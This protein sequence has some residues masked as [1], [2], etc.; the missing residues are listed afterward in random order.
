MTETLLNRLSGLA[1]FAFGVAL[2]LWLIPANTETVDYG[3]IRPDTVPKAC[4]WAFVALGLVQAALPRGRVEVDVREA[5]WVA[6]IAALSALAVWGM[7]RF[8]FLATGPVFAAV[9]VVLIREKRWYWAAA[10]IFGAP[11][12]TWLVVGVLLNRPLP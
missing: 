10:A 5:L 12:I 2:L 1:F 4:A 9:L 6:G 7:G 8:G 11:A 3:W